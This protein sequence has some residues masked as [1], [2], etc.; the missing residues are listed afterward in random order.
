MAEEETR[1][2]ARRLF[3]PAGRLDSDVPPQKVFYYFIFLQKKM[4]E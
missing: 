3:Y 1:M 2:N 4:K